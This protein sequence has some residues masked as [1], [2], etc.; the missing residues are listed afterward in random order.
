M[1]MKITGA[2]MLVVMGVAGTGKST[3]ARLLA[4]HLNWEFQEGDDLHPPANVAK[5]SAGTPLTDEDRWPWLD[6]IAAW[7][8]KKAQ[9]GEPGILTC[10][11][12]KRSYR[13]RLR[14]P[15]VIFVFLNGPPELIEARMASR[16]HHYMPVSLLH[17]QLA[18]LEPP[19]S[20]ENVLEISLSGE[21]KEQVAEVLK[22]LEGTAQA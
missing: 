8:E 5:M 10:S 16:K 21:P 9:R 2:P 17:S 12:L 3:V 14:G 11:A 22:V 6:A 19:T 7:I 18:T 13:D 20:D 4:Q 1:V 15:N